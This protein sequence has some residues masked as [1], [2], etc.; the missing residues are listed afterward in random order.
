M[1]ERFWWAFGLTLIAG[2]STGIGSVIALFAK[3]TNKAWLS[4]SM[5]FSAG[6]M[7]YVSFIDIFPKAQAHL[8][9]Q[10]GE[11]G[12]TWATV[13]AFFG[14]MLLIGLIDKLIP[15]HENP[16]EFADVDTTEEQDHEQKVGGKSR[17]ASL[18]KTGI[19]TA[20]A[21]GIHNFPEGLATFMA[22][23]QNLTLGVSIALAIAMHNIPEGIAVS[24]PVYFATHSKRKAFMYSFFSGISEPIGAILGFFLLKHIFNDLSFGII[25]ALVGG[26]MVFI[27]LDQLLPAAH[28]YGKHHHTIYGML[29]GMGMLALSLLLLM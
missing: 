15:Q 23:Y 28:K 4:V 24:I 3:H 18:Y 12:G 29:A 2:L 11:R 22:A 5:G 6:V 21:I 26:I 20:L 10:L 9:G 1:D 25:F 13:A 14:G 8:V 7:I 16:H 27:S 19:I 17:M